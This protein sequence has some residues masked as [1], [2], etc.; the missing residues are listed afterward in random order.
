MMRLHLESDL[1]VDP[2]DQRIQGI[3]REVDHCLTVG[4]LEMGM[5]GR[6]R[7][8]WRREGQVIDGG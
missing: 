4:A 8:G 3:Y 2:A 6:R 5:R 1:A 7:I